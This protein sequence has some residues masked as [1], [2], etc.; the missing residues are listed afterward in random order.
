M[1]KGARRTDPEE[2]VHSTREGEEEDVDRTSAGE[3]R[4]RGSLIVR[5]LGG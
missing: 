4:R 2:V 5:W 1:R 3:G